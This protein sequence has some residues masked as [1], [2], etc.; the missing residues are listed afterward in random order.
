MKKFFKGF[1]ATFFI[2]I[3]IFGSFNLIN[4]KQ[5]DSEINVESNKQ[6]KKLPTVIDDAYVSDITENSVYINWSLNT[7]VIEKIRLIRTGNRNS[8]TYV[9]EIL[10]PTVQN[11]RY[12]IEGL[13]PG[14]SY[15]WSLHVLSTVPW[16]EWYF[17]NIDPFTTL[18]VDNVM[19]PVI[20]ASIESITS[21]S[22]KVEW[23]I[24]DMDNVIDSVRLTG[25]DIG[26]NIH[27]G[28]DLGTILKGS[29]TISGLKSNH[30]YDSWKLIIDYN[31]VL[32][33]ELFYELPT[34]TT[35]S[36]GTIEIKDVSFKNA[37]LNSIDITWDIKVPKSLITITSIQLTG[38][39]L[40]DGIDLGTKASGRK[41]IEGLTNEKSYSDWV[42]S[43]KWN[44]GSSDLVTTKKIESFNIEDYI[45]NAKNI[46]II[47][48]SII[49]ILLLLLF[50]LWL[51]LVLLKRRNEKAIEQYDN[52]ESYDQYEEYESVANTELSEAYYDSYPDAVAS[53]E[54][55]EAYYDDYESVANTELSE[56]YYD[57]SYPEETAYDYY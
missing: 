5:V 23:D 38:E 27:E 6:T 39:D 52:Y 33:P 34:F 20:D 11:G 41:T 22:A 8:R 36:A 46:V 21:N 12:K 47:I 32:Y 49:G 37:T 53:T 2:A 24:F 18:G 51:L 14:T 57:D 7:T 10:L 35:D 16:F 29:K 44:D 42:F 9:N 15:S 50:L 54:L 1:I 30:K 45:S 28:I 40:G 55:S 13:R 56:A 17:Y 19:D 26:E 3:T 48:A 4:S 43:V 25:E 31:F